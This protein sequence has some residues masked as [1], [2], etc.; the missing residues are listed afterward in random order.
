M[1]LGFT[2]TREGMTIPQRLKVNALL[3]RLQPLEV[4]HGDCVGS[5]R[6]FHVIVSKRVRTVAHPATGSKLRAFCDADEIREPKPPL[7]RDRDIVNECHGLLATPRFMSEEQRSGT[8]YTT[9]YALRCSK[10]A[11]IVWP[12]GSVTGPKGGG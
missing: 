5:D 12:D 10:P 4:H 7:E 9:R 8:W 6:D 2:G 3:E 1:K 11:W